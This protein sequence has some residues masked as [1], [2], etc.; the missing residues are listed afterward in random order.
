LGPTSWSTHEGGGEAQPDWEPSNGGPGG[1]DPYRAW[2]NVRVVH[3]PLNA[4]QLLGL[5]AF[6][7]DVDRIRAAAKMQRVAMQAHRFESSPEI[8]ENVNAELEEAIRIL[9]DPDQKT[10]YDVHLRLHEEEIDKTP[11]MLLG[12]LPNRGQPG[13]LVCSQCQTPAPATRRFCS[14]C[15]SPLWEP[16]FRCGTLAMAGEKFCGACGANLLTGIEEQIRLFGIKLREAERLRAECRYEEASAL[17]VPFT[18]M[19]HSRLQPY[20]RR[21]HET[22]HAISDDRQR[23]QEEVKQRYQE[24]QQ[25]AAE[26]DYEGV[27]GLL[28]A[29]PGPLRTDTMTQLLDEMRMRLTQIAELDRQIREA[30]SANRVAEV[31]QLVDQL[32][33]LKPDHP[34]ALKLAVKFREHLIKASQK[35]LAQC[36]YE[37]AVSQLEQVPQA[38]RNEAWQRAHGRAAELVWLTWD[39]C[40]APVVDSTLVAFAERLLQQAPGDAKVK[41]AWEELRRRSQLGPGDS[42]ELAIRWAAAPKE[43]YVGWPVDWLTGFRRIGVKTDVNRTALLEHPSSFFVAAGLALQGL[44]KAAAKLNLLPGDRGVLGTV[45]QFWR[46]RPTR[47]AWGLDLSSSGLK[48]VKLSM[49]SQHVVVEACDFIEHRKLLSQ[50]VNEEEEKTLI[51]ETVKTFLSRNDIKSCRI[52]LGVPSRMVLVRQLKIPPLEETKMAAVLQLEA[53]RLMPLS[54][55]ELVW[56][57]EVLEPAK[58]EG[59]KEVDVVLVAVKRLPLKDRLAKLETL[60]LPVDV[61]QSD[62]LALHSLLSY[63]FG[64]GSDRGDETLAGDVNA[65]TA[66]VDV[67]SDTTNNLMVSPRLAWFYTSGLGC[68]HLTKALVRELQST[69]A[70]AEQLQRNPVL[71]ESLDPVLT[72]MNAFFEE[73]GQEIQSASALFAKAHRHKRVE[74]ILGVGGGFQTHGL[75]RY[76]RLGR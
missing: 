62:A 40:N 44:G 66:V 53:R 25:R 22:L 1:F 8:W 38:V 37:A 32:L 7:D 67:G 18:K 10:A 20:L 58:A 6:E 75:L 60:G 11:P 14:N 5:P 76:L 61:V 41:A 30:V 45:T 51:E 12:A 71:A 35:K 3:R 36:Q 23:A 4:Y 34:N 69:A 48:A 73:L 52:C 72:T 57:Y 59:R 56:G 26:G 68:Y 39:L 19:E 54:L 42:Q 63:E 49:D 55:E 15:G 28:E 70:Q 9:V 13:T 33:T 50:T 27:V 64:W 47:A 43:S 31:L 17:L 2:L 24:A 46:M 16:C 29:V 21:A 74:R 65:V